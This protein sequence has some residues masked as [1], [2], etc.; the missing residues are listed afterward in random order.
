MSQGRRIVILPWWMWL[1]LA[2]ALLAPLY[3]CAERY[4]SK[5]QDD[6][7]RSLCEQQGGCTVVPTPMWKQI[8]RILGITGT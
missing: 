8:E 4:L 3:G 7:M 1:C 5:E 2:L 6:E